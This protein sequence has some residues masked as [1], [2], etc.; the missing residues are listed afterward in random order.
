MS[1]KK[2]DV[3][4][5][6]YDGALIENKYIKAGL[7]VVKTIEQRN[8]LIKKLYR[9]L[10]P[11]TT[12]LCYVS[13]QSAIYELIS[14]PSNDATTDQDWKRL[15]FGVSEILVARGLW[16]A[17]NTN[18]AIADT[19]AVGAGNDFYVV[20]GAPTP[21]VVQYPG[22]FGGQSITVK[23][24][25]WIISNGSEWFN[26]SA[27]INWDSISGVPQTIL[28]Y[29]TGTVIGHTH[30]ISDVTGLQ[31]S[32]NLKFDSDDVGSKD[33]AFSSVPDGKLVDVLLLKNNF[34]Q[35]SETYS[36]TEVDN[37]VSA[38]SPLT[39]KGDILTSNG[40]D[41][42]V[43]PVGISGQILS[44]DLTQDGGLKWV[45]II[46]GTVSIIND[47]ITGGSDKALS[48]QQGVIL[49]NLI[50]SFIDYTSS[51]GVIL[52]DK[53]RKYGFGTGLALNGDLTFSELNASEGMKSKV[54]HNDVDE[55]TVNVPVGVTLTKVGEYIEDTDNELIFEC[56]K[57]D[58]GSVKWLNYEII[59]HI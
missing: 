28:D 27:P 52:L 14:D 22:L 20:T 48:A 10:D 35:K 24:G 7:F 40:V 29:V 5:P 6:N 9:T 30:A 51:S 46:S 18:P 58:S 3:L 2:S 50:L 8:T 43:L 53:N 15:D 55:P 44:V 23:D 38:I 57:D 25:D 31:D 11:E 42:E 12:T 45:D 4:E 17:S 39:D 59:N 37:I 56:V 16:D 33:I 36:Q 13:A 21:T 41:L 19:D 47:L 32:L 1:E 26:S 54:L 34:Y 49:N